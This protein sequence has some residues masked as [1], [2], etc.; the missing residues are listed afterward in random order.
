MSHLTQTVGCDWIVD[1]NA[2]EDQCGFCGGDG[3]SCQTVSEDFIK[4]VN[5]S[6][7]YYE[8]TLIPSGSRHILIEEMG[9]S[10]NYIGIGRADSNEYY[11]NGDR[12][13]SMSGEYQIA[14]ATGLYE[15]EN[16]MEKLKIPGPIKEDITLFVSFHKFPISSQILTKFSLSLCVS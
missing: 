3:S 8:I 5:M 15:R 13:I 6:E 12:L 2:T 7:G 14:G 4:K 9:A 1:S 11:L 10:K 16:E